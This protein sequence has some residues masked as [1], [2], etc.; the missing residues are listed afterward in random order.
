MTN[1]YTH[2][3]QLI[4]LGQLDQAIQS[5]RTLA[6]N[7]NCPDL[8]PHIHTLHTTYHYMKQYTLTPTQDPQ[9]PHIH[10]TLQRDAYHI[11][12]RLQAHHLIHTNPTLHTLHTTHTHHQFHTLALPHP[13]TPATTQDLQ[14]TLLTTTAA[15]AR[16]I[17]SALLLAQ[18]AIF[19]I[20]RFNALAHTYIHTTH[21]D[22][23]QYTLVAM[24][25]PR[26]DQYTTTIYA[27]DLDDTFRQLSLTPH[28]REDLAEL[29]IQTLLCLDTQDT[30]HTL[31]QLLHPDNTQPL[32]PHNEQLQLEQIE[33]NIQH[34]R[35]L[36]K[37]GAD[38]F[39]GGFAQ[40]KRFPFFHTLINWFLPFDIN[41]PQISTLPTGNIPRQAI[42]HLITTQPFCDTDKYSFLLA[43]SM[44]STQLPQDLI[45]LL[46]QGQ[47]HTPTPQD[48][49]AQGASLTRLLYLQDLYRFHKLYTRK[50]DFYDP[51]T[52]DTTATFFTWDK[53]QALMTE[54][55]YPLQIAKHLL[56]HTH[57]TSLD[58]LLD[59]YKNEDDILWLK[60]KALSQYK[61]HH[62]QAAL[63]W[64][65]QAL[66][67][68]PDNALLLKRTAQAAYQAKDYTTATH[69]YQ[70][71][72]HHTD[73][74][75]QDPQD[76]YQLALCYIHT[77]QPTKAKE[78]LFRLYFHDD[79]NPH[80]KLTL[81]TLHI[82]QK[83]YQKAIDMYQRLTP[84]TITPQHQLLQATT[85]WLAGN[86]TT[87]LTHYRNYT[88]IHH[89]T[90]Q[91]LLTQLLQDNTQY[92]LDITDTD[93]QILV[94]IIYDTTI[95]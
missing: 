40:A 35:Q 18:Y 90:P 29:Q 95:N 6:I 54:T 44:V 71:L 65:E 69:H 63:H 88:S 83:D 4:T 94:D 21:P 59:Q 22:I 17:I 11:L 42:A 91:D 14:H 48:L 81:A 58:R 39:F 28:I 89:T 3:A 52:D 75:H 66:T 26:P 15:E 92:H 93:I 78:I 67:H 62:Y 76:Q 68:Q 12:Q 82:I 50:E 24:M 37:S 73:T 87:A 8:T 2:I 27:E 38:I 85:H 25:L 61:Q 57:Y 16:V 46:S 32:Q 60:I 86:K 34:I 45:D 49:P 47:A 43:L 56:T 64:F 41:H 10:H 1:N 20:Q 79:Q 23:R 19:D 30:H 13:L 84:D 53:V 80:Y 70:Q 51:F 36:Q 74:T 9:R 55:D 72:I 5:L 33:Q 7:E 77:N 31:D